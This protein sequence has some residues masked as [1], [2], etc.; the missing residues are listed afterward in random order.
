MLMLCKVK[1]LPLAASGRLFMQWWAE[2]SGQQATS[3]GGGGGTMASPA[4]TRSL[5]QDSWPPPPQPTASVQEA[6]L[7]AM[8]HAAQQAAQLAATY[9]SSLALQ[10]LMYSLC[11]Q[12][13][14]SMAVKAWHAGSLRAG[15]SMNIRLFSSKCSHTHSGNGGLLHRGLP[16]QRQTSCTS[17]RSGMRCRVGSHR[18]RCWTLQGGRHSRP[19]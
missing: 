16:G 1:V 2:P 13:G 9:G 17:W 14:R 4:E 10:V 12:A 3:G 6:A 15:S 11:R 8:Q 19:H 5:R 18:Q 7:A